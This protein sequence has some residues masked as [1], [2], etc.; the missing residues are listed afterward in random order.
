M[1]RFILH[2]SNIQGVGVAKGVAGVPE[3]ADVLEGVGEPVGA[4]V[5]VGKI[6]GVAVWTPWME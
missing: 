1:K 4:G 6:A 5:L 3:L 2:L